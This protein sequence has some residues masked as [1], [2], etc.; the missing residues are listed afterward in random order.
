MGVKSV[1]SWNGDMSFDVELQG[2]RF[3][4]DASEEFGGKNRGPRPKPLL[5]A[6]LGGCTGMDVVSLLK[7]MKMPFDSFSLEVEGETAS[8]HPKPYKSITIKYIFKGGSLDR[9]KIDKAIGLSLDKYCGV[10][11]M[12]SKTA[13]INHQVLLNP[14]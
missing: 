1:L 4:V 8:E 6:G 11:A 13:Q 10:Y 5:L 3:A 7:K 2:H 9:E 12:L 14:S